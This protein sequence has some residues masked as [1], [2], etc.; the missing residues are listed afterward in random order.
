MWSS[1]N[2][3]WE[4]MTVAELGW[5][6]GAKYSNCHRQKGCPYRNSAMIVTEG[7]SQHLPGRTLQYTPIAALRED[8]RFRRADE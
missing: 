8:R 2:V 1:K 5:L 7:I 6:S 4:G 3:D